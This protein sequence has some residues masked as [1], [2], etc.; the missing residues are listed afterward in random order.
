MGLRFIIVLTLRTMELEFRNS[1]VPKQVRA[2]RRKS[3]VSQVL[4][5]TVTITQ[6]N[7]DTAEQVRFPPTLPRATVTEVFT[8]VAKVFAQ[9]TMPTIAGTL[10]NMGHTCV[11]RNIFVVITAVVRTRVET[12]AGFLTVLGSYIRR[13]NRVDPVIGL[14]NISMVKTVVTSGVRS[15][16]PISLA[17]CL[18]TTLNLKSFAV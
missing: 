14:R 18:F 8:K 16:M 13:G 17:S 11:I 12:G 5:F 6:F 15:F 9:V 4:M 2:T 10:L 7:R 3:L 1:T